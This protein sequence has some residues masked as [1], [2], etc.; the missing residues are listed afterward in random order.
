[1]ETKYLGQ[2]RKKTSV[3]SSWLR[4]HSPI[5]NCDLFVRHEEFTEVCSNKM[6]SGR[7]N[8]I[9]WAFLIKQLFR[10]RLLDITHLVGYL[11]SYIQRALVE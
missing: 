9:L 10:S 6:K 5:D 2:L 4:S 3:F 11:P 1:M 8:E 7:F